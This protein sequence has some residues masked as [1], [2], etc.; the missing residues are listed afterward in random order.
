ME[1]VLTDFDSEVCECGVALVYRSLFHHLPIVT[2]GK[3]AVSDNWGGSENMA[4]C[5]QLE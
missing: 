5:S 2:G 4:T 1:T 3:K